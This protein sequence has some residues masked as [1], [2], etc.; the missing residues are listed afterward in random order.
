MPIN[1]RRIDLTED[2][3]FTLTEESKEQVKKPLAVTPRIKRMCVTIFILYLIPVYFILR[4]YDESLNSIYYLILGSLIYFNYHIVYL[5][6]I[7]NV[8]IEKC[9]YLLRVL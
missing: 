1:D 8:P 9:V 2:K 7:I 4:Y 6:N 3:L 5:A